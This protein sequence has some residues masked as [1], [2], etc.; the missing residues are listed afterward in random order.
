MFSVAM[1]ARICLEYGDITGVLR[2]A[3]ISF[4]FG[5]LRAVVSYCEF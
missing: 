2:R 5:V 3:S 4:S 1:S